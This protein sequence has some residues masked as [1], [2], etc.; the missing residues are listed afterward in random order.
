MFKKFSLKSKLLSFTVMMSLIGLAIGLSGF[1]SLKAV[2]SDYHHITDVNMPKIS[3][4]SDMFLQFRRI[5]I[6]L[7]TLGLENVSE[8]IAKSSVIDAVDAIEK[9]EDANKKYTA[10]DFVPGEKEIYEPLAETWNSFKTLGLRV[11]DLHK[12]ATPENHAK[13]MEIFFKDC[14]ELAAKFKERMEKLKKFNEDQAAQWKLQALDSAT[15]ANSLAFSILLIGIGISLAIGFVFANAITKSIRSVSDELEKGAVAVGSAAEKISQA[16]V[17]LAESTTEQAAALQ[18]TTSALEE[19][20]AMISKNAENA[21]QSSSVSTTSQQ[22]AQ[23]GMAV[24]ND[25]VHSIEDI[26]GSNS[27]IMAQ[28][29]DSNRE[30]E[31]IVKVIA[32]IGTKTKVINDIVFQTKLLSFNASVEAARAGEHG[33][34][35]AVVA[36]E[37]GKLAQMSGNSAK[38]ISQLLDESIHKVENII[39]NTKARV[40][41]LV[42]SGKE[43]I[44]TGTVTARRCSEVLRSIVENVESVGSMVKEISHASQEQSQGVQE[45]SKAMAQLDQVAQQNDATSQSASASATELKGQ[46]NNLRAMV[47]NLNKTVMGDK[48]A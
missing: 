12:L 47:D 6:A 19:T 44:N 30:I 26:A 22:T 45:I 27:E 18:E 34:G 35:F 5:R 23:Q 15:K 36:E 13:M 29:E 46:V 40:E 16:S 2:S 25:M 33:K 1:F 14:P 28:I 37:V 39:Q 21:K 38:E 10:V 17:T 3:N 32:E 20:S 42:Q 24:V 48:A 9:F 31:G 41:Q 8:S 4:L 11:V 43:K 7:R